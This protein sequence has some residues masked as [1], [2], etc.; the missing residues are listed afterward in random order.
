MLCLEYE[1]SSRKEARMAADSCLIKARSSATVYS[2]PRMRNDKVDKDLNLLTLHARIPL[3]KAGRNVSQVRY[4]LIRPNTFEIMVN[5]G[6]R[7]RRRCGMLCYAS[8]ESDS[9]TSA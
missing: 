2:E 1:S 4:I 5:H 7:R 9:E 8:P 6:G 3:I